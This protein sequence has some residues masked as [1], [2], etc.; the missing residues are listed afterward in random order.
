MTAMR[1]K[2][3]LQRWDLGTEADLRDSAANDGSEPRLLIFCAP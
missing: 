2:R 3:A 1:R